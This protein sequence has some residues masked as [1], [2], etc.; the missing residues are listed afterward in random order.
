MGGETKEGTY[1]QPATHHPPPSLPGPLAGLE[2]AFQKHHGAV[3]RA[4]YRIT[5]SAEDAEDV[6]QTVFVRLLRREEEVDLDE[7]AGSYLHRAAVNAALDL[8][9][10]R[11]RSRAV[12]LEQVEGELADEPAAGPEARRK[13]REV[14]ARLREALT[15]LSP[16]SAEIFALRYFE[17]LTN[18]EIAGLLGTSQTAIAVMLH[19]TRHRLRKDL[20]PF[21]GDV[22]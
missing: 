14:T 2:A 9:R 1:V 7:R 16:R 19:R 12:A 20:A 13:S 4:A 3:F 8:V 11:K 5:G 22:S 21:E 10:R 17:G 15:R 6:L 18:L